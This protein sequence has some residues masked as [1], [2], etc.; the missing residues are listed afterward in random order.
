MRF[1]LLTATSAVVGIVLLG[2]IGTSVKAA[3][4]GY[5][6]GDKRCRNGIRQVY[7]C[8]YDRCR[9]RNTDARCGKRKYGY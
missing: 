8:K 9:W 2:S 3:P 4:Y 7:K 1:T 6:A 5:E